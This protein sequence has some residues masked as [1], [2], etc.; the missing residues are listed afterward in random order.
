MVI[1]QSILNVTLP[2]TSKSW[3]NNL[4]KFANNVIKDNGKYIIKDENKIN[5]EEEKNDN[6]NEN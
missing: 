5:K 6:K 4:K 1:P 2:T 3:F